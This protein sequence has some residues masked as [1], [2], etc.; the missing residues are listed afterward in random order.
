MKMKRMI[1]ERNGLSYSRSSIS[2]TGVLPRAGF[3][4]IELLVVVAIIAILAAILLPALSSAKEKA[5]QIMC[6]NNMRQIASL[7]MLYA[8]DFDGEFIL[9]RAPGS[10]N[11]GAGASN[12]LYWYQ[13]IVGA[14]YGRAVC[15]RFG[16][17]NATEN[18]LTGGT[19][20]G[21]CPTSLMRFPID[22]KV[23]PP[24]PAD[25]YAAYYTSYRVNSWMGYVGDS[26]A[27]RHGASKNINEGTMSARTPHTHTRKPFYYS[28]RS[29]SGF[30]FLGENY[31]RG[32][33]IGLVPDDTN[34]AASVVVRSRTDFGILI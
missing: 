27:N 24:E 13:G 15:S 17:Y 9:Q 3:T 26:G 11:E 23:V 21:Q 12:R 30:L 20:G 10:V 22:K 29:V 8:H 33:Y 2:Y 34:K 5:R 28:A 31:I 25:K 4:L 32:K 16:S 1:S 6:A 19:D 18:Y 14:H 7:C